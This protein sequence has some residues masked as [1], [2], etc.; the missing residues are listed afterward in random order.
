MKRIALADCNN[1][2]ASCERV[3][4][5]KLVKKPVVILSSNDG[6]I[7]AR[8]N[9]AKKL[10]IKMGEPLFKCADLIKKYNV[11]V[12]SSNFSLYGDMSTRVMQTLS[13]F[14]TEIEIY[15]I[16]EAFFYFQDPIEKFKSNQEELNWYTD[17]AQFIRKQVQQKTGIPVSIGLGPT[18]TLAKLANSLAKK[19]AVYENVLDLTDHPNL[20]EILKT[21][22]VGDIWGIG[23]RYAD[24]LKRHNIKTAYELKQCDEV[25]IRKNLTI[26]GLKTVLELK[27][28]PCITLEDGP[29]EKKSI[30]VSRSFGKNI[31]ELNDL[32]EAIAYH[33]TRAAEKLRMQKTSA[34]VITIFVGFVNYYD[35]QKHYLSSTITL[36][37]ASSYTPELIK[38]AIN[39]L[40]RLFKKG[41]MYKKAG[42]ILSDFCS[43]SYIQLNPFEAI[44][45]LTKQ[46]KAMETLDKINF[47]MGRNK[48]FFAA[49]GTKH[50]WKPRLEKKSPSY[51]TN[52]HELLTIKI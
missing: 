41:V 28:M 7:I 3:F 52:W 33:A 38:H 8:S 24:F 5:P 31:T 20:D 44:P 25:W 50:A 14:A 26:N 9:E 22:E 40:E 36:P 23:Y 1:F 12:Y 15:S 6:C 39:C 11:F 42:I 43:S 21:V 49:S 17:H 34:S 4:N 27:G 51:T 29:E 13:E 30:T 16:D 45:D 47:K 10:G 48:L 18:K 46:S 35:P 37:M 32:K 2:F 19:N